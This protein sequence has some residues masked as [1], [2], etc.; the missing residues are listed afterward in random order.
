M[1]QVRTNII[2]QLSFC[3]VIDRMDYLRTDYLERIFLKLKFQL[4]PNAIEAKGLSQIYGNT[5]DEVLQEFPLG[6]DTQGNGAAYRTLRIMVPYIYIYLYSIL[7]LCGVI[8][9]GLVQIR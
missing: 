7:T 2:L 3:T 4:S 8:L 1:I 5:Q 9:A 6:F